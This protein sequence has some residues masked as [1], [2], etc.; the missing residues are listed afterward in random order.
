MNLKGRK[1]QLGHYGHSKMAI[2]VVVLEEVS[3]RASGV[4]FGD[5]QGSTGPGLEEPI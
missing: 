4:I 5:V 1:F 2:R 3:W